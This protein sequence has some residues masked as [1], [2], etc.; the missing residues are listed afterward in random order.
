MKA[1]KVYDAK[2]DSQFE[3]PYIDTEEERVRQVNGKSVPYLYVHGGFEGT[4]VRFSYCFPEKEG[5]K[6][7]FFHYL[8]PF[9]GSE[10]EM[11]SQETFGVDDRVGFAITHGAYF[12]ESNM[13]SRAQFG[14]K[15]DSTLTW[16]SSAAVAEYSREVAQRLYGQHRVY[17]YV[18]GGSGGGFKTMDCIERTSA[19]DGAVPYVIGSPT[20]LPN[21]MTVRVHAMRLLRNKFPQIVDALEPGGN[22]DIYAGLDEEEK[23]ALQEATKMGFPPKAWFAY[24]VMGDGSLAV[25]GPQVGAAD[26]TYLEDFWSKPGYLGAQKDGSAVRDRLQFTGKIKTVHFSGGGKQKTTESRNNADDAWQKALEP[27]LAGKSWIELEQVPQGEDLYLTGTSIL[28]KT[29]KAAGKKLLLD[30]IQD[31]LVLIGNGFGCDSIEGV[32]SEL[33][34]GDEILLDNS[35]Y[36]AMQTYHRHKIGGKEFLPYDQFRDQD[37]KPLYPQREKLLFQDVASGQSGKI[38]GKVIVVESLWDES[39][40]PWQADWYRNRVASA[41]E[42]DVDGIMRLWYMDHCSHG[43]LDETMGNLYL[44]PYVSAVRQALLDVSDWVERG[45][46]PL[47]TTNYWVEDGQV[48]VPETAEERLGIQPVVHLLVNGEKC[49]RIRVGEEA[50]FTARIETPPEAGIVTGAQWSFEGETDFPGRGRLELMEKGRNAIASSVHTYTTPGTYFAAV[51][52]HA[53]RNGNAG[54]LYTQIKNLDRVRVIVE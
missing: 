12:V 13:G 40:L 50:V 22:G 38:Q 18:H 5:Y 3:K 7:R 17:G 36:I 49:V 34:A 29:G 48:I 51:R 32:L 39:A 8:S 21:C 16:R 27:E 2:T 44:V 33:H 53:E 47:Q 35:D 15:K 41:N 25:L 26:P 31:N 14:P 20:S 9:P 10:E 46:A 6:G 42:G 23:A 19:F 37:H 52:V 24:D 4:T 43:D 54:D 30:T 1:D 45:I 11:A 28:V